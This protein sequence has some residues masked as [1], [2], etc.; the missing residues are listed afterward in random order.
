MSFLSE[1]EKS[2]QPSQL[3]LLPTL[4][5]N[6]DGDLE[7]AKDLIYLSAEMKA[8]AAK[9]QNFQ[10]SKIVSR[11]GFDNLKGK[12]S[13]QAKWKK[14]VY[15][16][17]E[18]ASLSL[19]WTPILKETCLKAGIDYFTSPYDFDSVDAVDPYVD[20][21]KIGSGDITWIEIL[22]HIA[23]KN[24]PVLLATG[25]SDLEDVKRA[26]G[27]LLTQTKRICLM[28]CNTNYTGSL[29]NF[30]YI[31]LSVL[32]TFSKLFPDVVLGL[33]DH[34]PGH[35]TVLGAVTLGA[36]VV[37]K[38][39]TDDNSRIG[40]DHA[41]AMNPNSWLEMVERTREVEAAMGDGIKRVEGNEADSQVVQ[42]RA[43]RA[44]KDLPAGLVIERH[45]LEPLRPIPADGLPPYRLD[46]LVGR[47]L[48][49][50]LAQ[51]EHITMEYFES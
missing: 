16:I 10:A 14:S 32:K 28:Q 39:F 49:R 36:R 31:N 33:S 51:G 27:F 5:R 22:G 40:P 38:H 15:E 13:H 12:L 35:S 37:E 44:T 23:K 45:H 6:H 48:C 20:V 7:R 30:R 1:R 46:D 18:D 41:F 47:K 50:P 43:L 21:Y 26:M 17:Y 29:E 19:D 11:K 25:A 24:K 2:V 42:R 34:T 9:F 4:P 3:I 8:D